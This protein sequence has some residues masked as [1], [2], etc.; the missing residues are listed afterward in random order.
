M[1]GD[2]NPIE[3]L[4]ASRKG[5]AAYLDAAEAE[6]AMRLARD[7]ERGGLRARVTQS[8]DGVRTGDGGRRGPTDIADAALDARERV[9]KALAAVGPE[10][11]G[12]LLDVCCFDK[13]LETIEAE[14]RWPVRSGKLMVKTGLAILARH[15]GLSAAA[16]GPVRATGMRAW[17]TGDHRPKIGG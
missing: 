14:R 11:S 1:A 17:G 6:A 16:S 15:Y 13:G 9:N 12:L 5:G 2:A 3:R 4:S 7:A 10:F 8:W